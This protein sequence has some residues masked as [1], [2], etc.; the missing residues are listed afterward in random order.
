MTFF[1]KKSTDLNKINK[2]IIPNLGNFQTFKISQIK[3]QLTLK[4]IE[5]RI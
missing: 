1:F 3:K 2:K 5:V 4:N